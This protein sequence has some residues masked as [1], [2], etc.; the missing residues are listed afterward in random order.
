MADISPSN[1]LPTAGWRVSV[2]K[3][4]YDATGYYIPRN[5]HVNE[6]KHE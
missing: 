3:S 4:N 2:N 1:H 5:A 6:E